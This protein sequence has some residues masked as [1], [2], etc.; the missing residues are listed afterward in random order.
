MAEALPQL[1]KALRCLPGVGPKSAQR[2][3][4][5]LLLRNRDGARAL[6][7]ALTSAVERIGSCERCRALSE[8]PLCPTCTDPARDPAQLCIVEMPSDVH[9]L[10]S[11]GCFRGLYFVLNGRLSPLDGIGPDEL[12][13]ERLDQR[14]GENVVR[15]MV[16]AT[17]AT[18]EGEATAHYLGQMAQRHG[19]RATRI[20]YGVPLGGELEY[21]DGATLS[22]A[23]QGR[24]EF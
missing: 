14:L 22:L 19:V 17:N 11:A 4:F 13:L 18:V 24:R 10:D 20:A 8:T 16:I 2:M 21:L 3:A 6:A 9:A 5:H 7:A 12:G 23:F 1:I 15:E